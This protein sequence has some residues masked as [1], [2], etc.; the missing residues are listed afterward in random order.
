MPTMLVCVPN[1]FLPWIRLRSSTGPSKMIYS[2]FI[3]NIPIGLYSV[4]RCGEDGLS[5]KHLPY[6]VTWTILKSNHGEP[7]RAQGCILD[8]PSGAHLDNR[9]QARVINCSLLSEI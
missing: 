7:A 3:I 8:C 1:F 9:A 6:S 4:A 5:N 2:H